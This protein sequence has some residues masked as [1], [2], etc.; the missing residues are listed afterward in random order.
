MPKKKTQEA[1]LPGGLEIR[2]R[3]L[4]GLAIWVDEINEKTI[5]WNET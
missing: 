4:G 3:S 1:V 2:L 5:F